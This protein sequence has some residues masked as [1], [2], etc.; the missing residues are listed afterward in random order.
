MG[1]WVISEKNIVKTDL[2]GKNSC[3]E[4]PG[5]KNSYTGRAYNDGKKFLR[6][7]MSGKNIFSP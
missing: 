7:C 5:E 3:T 6:C 1:I 4:I 2:E